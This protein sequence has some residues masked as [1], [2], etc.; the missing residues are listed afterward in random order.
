MSES[1]YLHLRLFKNIS[2]FVDEVM[3][4]ARL[5]IS[6]NVEKFALFDSQKMI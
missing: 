4:I 6:V 3:K 1:K 2:G 5:Q